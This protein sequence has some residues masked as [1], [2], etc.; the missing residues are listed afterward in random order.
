MSD[1]KFACPH[2]GQHLEAPVDMA[3]QLI[4]CPSCS[5]PIEVRI[6]PPQT[7]DPQLSQQS[8]QPRNLHGLVGQTN[9][10]SF[11]TAEADELSS[12]TTRKRPRALLYCLLVVGIVAF[13]GL[14]IF[15]RSHPQSPVGV[16]KRYLAVKR[17]E[18]RLPYVL[19]SDKVKE[20]MRERYKNFKGPSKFMEIKTLSDTALSTDGWT[21]VY[22]LLNRRPGVLGTETIDDA[23]FYVLKTDEGYKI[24]WEATTIANPMSLSEFKARRPRTPVT[25]RLVASL[26]SDSGGSWLRDD[27]WFFTMA[28]QNQGYITALAKKGSNEGEQLFE[29]VRGGKR[30]PVIVD[31]GYDDE[32][33]EYVVDRFVQFGWAYR[34]ASG[35]DTG[36]SEPRSTSFQGEST[37]NTS[38]NTQAAAPSDARIARIP[39]GISD[40][41]W[42][43]T[44][45]QLEAKTGMLSEAGVLG[46]G[47]FPLGWQ[48]EYALCLL[49]KAN[50]TG[51]GA[52]INALAG[53]HMPPCRRYIVST[54]AIS[55][56]VNSNQEDSPYNNTVFL[57]SKSGAFWGYYSMVN[58]D[59]ETDLIMKLRDN[60]GC[61][62]RELD[63]I[64]TTYQFPNGGE[65]T[66]FFV[67]TRM[68]QDARST[69]YVIEYSHRQKGYFVGFL[70]LSKELI[71]SV[72]QIRDETRKAIMNSGASEDEQRKKQREHDLRREQNLF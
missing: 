49:L 62:W 24:D 42:G 43:A 2:C 72:D 66:F 50:Q 4:D 36:Q 64:E 32:I 67:G 59:N 33:E 3:G 65:S 51:Y 22:V 27:F 8:P 35:E 19:H 14:T 13:V 69:V 63:P 38:A 15:F 9:N 30:I 47:L 48:I 55:P 58:P 60:Y 10:D 20:Q 16:V 39:E 37:T 41:P 57:F 7:V 56:N 26:D 12:N 17:W 6:T 61:S 31:V 34:E 11:K 70:K 23:Y 71:D 5:R 68:W 18:D 28:I 1:I 29:L 46:E 25:L 52:T 21:L 45:T 54:R 44:E 53:S 40:V